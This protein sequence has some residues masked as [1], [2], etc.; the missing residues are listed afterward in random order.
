MERKDKNMKVLEVDKKEI[1]SLMEI[2]MDKDEAETL[3]RYGRSHIVNDEQCLINYAVNKIL[4]ESIDKEYGKD[5]GDK[6][7][8]DKAKS[9][10]KKKGGKKLHKR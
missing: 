2:E 10:R 7:K 5:Y 4:K 9:S 6:N 8:K 3:L 1:F